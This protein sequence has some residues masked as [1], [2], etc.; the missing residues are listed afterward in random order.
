MRRLPTIGQAR[1]SQKEHQAL[2]AYRIDRPPANPQ[3]HAALVAHCTRIV[4]TLQGRLLTRAQIR[5]RAESMANEAI[6]EAS[7]KV[8][9]PVRGKAMVI[10]APDQP[11][12]KRSP[13]GII[14][15]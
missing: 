11:E 10:Q 3:E 7:N 13:G 15:P 5:I 8:R 9:E 6:L 12:E 14:L 4:A 1:R 2:P